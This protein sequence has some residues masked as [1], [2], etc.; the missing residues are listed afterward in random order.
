MKKLIILGLL[1]FGVSSSA[2]GETIR[3]EYNSAGKIVNTHYNAPGGSSAF[4]IITADMI[5]PDGRYVKCIDSYAS[6]AAFFGFGRI[7]S[8]DRIDFIPDD[9]VSCIRIVNR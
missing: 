9:K 7:G 2:F 5:L 3:V 4:V 1:I 6:G 8:P